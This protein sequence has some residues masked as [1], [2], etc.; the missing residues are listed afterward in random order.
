[1][2]EMQRVS[3][4]SATQA[5]D[6][7]V[8]WRVSEGQLV[9]T[10]Y[11]LA[12]LLMCWLVVPLVALIVRYARTASH[13]YE[14]TPERL[15]ESTGLLFRKT[16]DLELYRVQDVAIEEPLFQRLFGYGTVLLQTSDRSTPLVRLSCVSHPCARADF[17][18]DLV[19]RCRV[20][21]GVREINQQR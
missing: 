4:A 14:L 17:L 10:G 9:N 18:R 1:M 15:R 2:V 11:F 6:T 3:A 19:E 5:P 13:R 7:T 16:D 21:K 12:C 8:L 20:A